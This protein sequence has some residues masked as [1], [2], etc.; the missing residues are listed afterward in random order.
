MMYIIV[1]NDMRA[2]VPRFHWRAFSM[3]FVDVIYVA[4]L[5]SAGLPETEERHVKSPT[6]P[7]TIVF[8]KAL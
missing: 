4:Q 6:R 5:L 2:K 1:C 3:L 7:G 8:D